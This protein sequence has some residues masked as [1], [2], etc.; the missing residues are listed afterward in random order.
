MSAG[1]GWIKGGFGWEIA[2][3]IIRRGRPDA[4]DHRDDS[5]IL[6][7]QIYKNSG[8][9]NGQKGQGPK[10]EGG[11]QRSSQNF[12]VHGLS[13]RISSDPELSARAERLAQLIAGH[14]SGL[15][16]PHEA[17]V[18]AEAQEELQRVR[19]CRLDRLAQPSLAKKPVPV[20]AHHA[21]LK[22]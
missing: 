18:I 19:R 1:N 2:R 15:E 9:P 3:S 22:L 10:S 8:R 7:L 21:I 11:R 4:I 17:R 20:R 6:T 12:L 14:G 13:L 16:V 5:V